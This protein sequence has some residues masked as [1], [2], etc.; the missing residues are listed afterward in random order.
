MV[1][2]LGWIGII[3]AVVVVLFIIY[4]YNSLIKLNVRANNAWSQIDVQL[5][6]RFVKIDKIK[7]NI[8]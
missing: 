5:K 4:I 2:T 8:K 6:R 1:T 3:I 7:K